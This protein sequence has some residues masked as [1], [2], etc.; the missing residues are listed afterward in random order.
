NFYFSKNNPPYW[1]RIEGSIP[2]LLVRL[3]VGDKLSAVNWRLRKEGL[4]LFLFDAW[5]PRAG[6]AYFHDVWTPPELRRR[7]P[8]LEGDALRA[9]VE[10]YWAA[11]TDDPMSP[12]P[13][14][15]GA[16]LDLTI[17]IAGG[18]PLWMGSMFDDA[19]PLAHRD[20]FERE[21]ASLAFS[22]EEA[23]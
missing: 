22:D 17:R 5:R 2:H 18:E 1:Q 4:E 23:Q 3:S 8:S 11:P 21:S 20:R 7:G 19:T 14:S 9:E 16:A 6:Q 15:T 13:H 10:R 12:A